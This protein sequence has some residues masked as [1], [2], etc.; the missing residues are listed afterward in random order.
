[1]EFQN[2]LIP[3]IPKLSPVDSLCLFVGKPPTIICLWTL[4]RENRCLLSWAHFRLFTF[5]GGREEKDK[6]DSIL[7]A[8]NGFGMCPS[9]LR[10]TMKNVISIAMGMLGPQYIELAVPMLEGMLAYKEEDRITARNS[11]VMLNELVASLEPDMGFHCQP[12]D[13]AGME[14]DEPES[15][16]EDE[17]DAHVDYN[18]LWEQK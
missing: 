7:R 11:A 14:I 3:P 13:E 9:Q 5:Q 1:M 10:D 18:K 15:S 16:E 4:R 2:S 17:S 6:Q 12:V 8:E